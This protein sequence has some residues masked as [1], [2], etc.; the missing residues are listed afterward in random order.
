[1][2]AGLPVQSTGQILP[3]P[4]SGDGGA[5]SRLRLFR[6]YIECCAADARPISVPIEFSTKLPEFKEMGWYQV[7]GTIRFDK[8][9]DITNPVV[10]DAEIEAVDPPEDQ[11]TF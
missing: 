7:N 4:K 8:D 2:L 1:M 10:E 5:A 9:G 11:L 6:L 3:D